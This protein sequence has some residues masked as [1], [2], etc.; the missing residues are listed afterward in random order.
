MSSNYRLDDMLYPI[1]HGCTVEIAEV[2]S[3][4]LLDLCLHA[5]SRVVISDHPNIG[6]S[7]LSLLLFSHV[8]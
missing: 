6:M 4:V 7:H 1:E 8:L 5:D 2:L 3:G